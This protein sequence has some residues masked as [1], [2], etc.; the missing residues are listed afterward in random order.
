MRIAGNEPHVIIL[1]ETIPKAQS[2]PISPALLAIFLAIFYSNF[3]CSTANLGASGLRGIC[4]YVSNILQ[5][6]QVTFP[7][8]SFQEQLWMKLRLRNS[9]CLL[10]GCIYC[11]PTREAV[12]NTEELCD[13]LH[14]VCLTN[15][16]H[17]ITGDFNMPTI[18]WDSK[19]SSAPAGHHSHSFIEA[20]NGYFLFQ[21]VFQPTRYRHGETPSVLDLVFSNEENMVKNLTYS[22]G[23]GASDHVIL[24]FDFSC[25]SLQRKQPGNRLDLSRA[26]FKLLNNRLRSINWDCLHHLD[27]S[28]SYAFFKAHIQECIEEAVPLSR[29]PCKKK[30]IYINRRALQ[31]KKTKESLWKQYVSSK[32][33][34]DHARFTRFRNKL[35]SYTRWLRLNFESQLVAD[36]KDNPKAFW[37]YANSR[38]KTRSG[39]DALQ[40]ADGILVREDHEKAGLLNQFFSSVF[41]IENTSHVPLTTWHFEGAEIKDI[42]ISTDCIRHKLGRLK[43]TGS[44]GPDGIPSRVL[45]ETADS[46]ALPLSI[47]FQQSLN[48]GQLPADWKS[49]TVVP[50]YKK[51]C[52]SLPE[53]YRPVSLTSVVCKILES[54]VRDQLMDFLIETN[55]ISPHQHGFRSKRSCST[56][57]LEVMEDWSRSLE[58]GE[59]LD[60][61]YLDFKK[62]FDAVPHQRL[63][64]KLEA[65]GVAGNLLKWIEAFISG[66]KQQVLVGGSHSQWSPVTSGVPQGSVL[67]PLLFLIYI[68]DM[69]EVV[70]SSIKIL[71]MTLKY[72]A[73]FHSVRKLKTSSKTSIQLLNGRTGGSCHLTK[74]NA[75]VC[76]LGLETGIRPTG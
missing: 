36:I 63:M 51:G 33:L 49:G 52:K 24:E 46:I 15:P 70:S 66:R 20:V 29:P 23:L 55:Q 59:P 43:V 67:G 68:N 53:N 32:N 61:I 65:Y 73:G 75:S 60:V 54:V 44:P 42:I 22:A 45:L 47:L 34:I 28:N 6:I 17:L 14:H 76:T 50:I 16:S 5:A 9:D 74:A 71:L 41:T 40:D 37:K 26:N 19:F 48:S 7:T 10:I 69:P 56:Q 62:A 11:S 12:S 1:T 25:Y 3:E 57:L 30:N 2:I 18:D 13:L 4:I 38:L 27:F 58:D 8:S 39:I 21:H 64:R 72:T 35:R 31:M